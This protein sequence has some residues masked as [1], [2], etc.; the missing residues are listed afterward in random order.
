MSDEQRLALAAARTAHLTTSLAAVRERQLPRTDA[1]LEA[2]TSLSA[3][4][5]FDLQLVA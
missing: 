1:V 2:L 5:E 3:A 4:T